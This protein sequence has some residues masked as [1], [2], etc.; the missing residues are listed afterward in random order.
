MTDGHQ[1]DVLQSFLLV[2]TYGGSI[3]HLK[4]EASS[5]KESRR[6]ATIGVHPWADL[7]PMGTV[8]LW[9]VIA[10]G[11]YIYERLLIIST[12]VVGVDLR[13]NRFL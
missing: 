3:L 8:F 10:L 2:T 1:R 11:Y 6:E 9:V 4:S 13:C 12:Q 5:R 7:R